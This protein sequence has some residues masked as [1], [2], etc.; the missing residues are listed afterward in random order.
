MYDFR[1]SHTARKSAQNEPGH[2]GFY[3]KAASTSLSVEAC[4][5][6]C[7]PLDL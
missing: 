1:P 5:L 6:H 7:M 2:G 3:N 4:R